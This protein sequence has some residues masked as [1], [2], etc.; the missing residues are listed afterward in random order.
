MSPTEHQSVL[1]NVP[2]EWR[3]HLHCGGNLKPHRVMCCSQNKQE[4]NTV[5]W[6]SR[7][8]CPS[9]PC[10]FHV[11]NCWMILMTFGMPC[12]LCHW[13][14]VHIRGLWAL[15]VKYNRVRHVETVSVRP[16]VWE[17][18]ALWCGAWGRNIR[19]QAGCLN[20]AEF[21]CVLCWEHSLW[22]SV[23][24]SVFQPLCI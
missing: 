15:F 19:W 24:A 5:G 14:L 10:M 11:R 4:S 7:S 6:S 18:C 20:C 21:C 2:E 8:G 16:S 9:V 3:S 23:L 13:R 1:H 12:A 17:V 22:K